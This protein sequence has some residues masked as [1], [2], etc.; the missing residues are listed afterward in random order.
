MNSRFTTK[1]V[2]SQGTT[3]KSKIMKKLRRESSPQKSRAPLIIHETPAENPS[4]M[5]N[6]ASQCPHCGGWIIVERVMDFY[7]HQ[8]LQ[9]CLNCGRILVNPF[10]PMN[11]AHPPGMRPLQ[12]E[13]NLIKL[14][15]TYLVPFHS[16]ENSLENSLKGG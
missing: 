5:K 6:P 8:T 15:S 7:S 13:S 3:S 12:R 2:R 4:S 1:T 11:I 14:A 16:P 9:K 10:L